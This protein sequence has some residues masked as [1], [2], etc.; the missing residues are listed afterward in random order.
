MDS[1]TVLLTH[2]ARVCGL[3]VLLSCSAADAAQAQDRIEIFGALTGILSAPSGTVV[4]D[5]APPLV[6]G[7]LVRSSAGQTLPVIG[8]DGIGVQAGI[9]LFASS[10]FG[11][12]VI[13]DRAN[14]DLSARNGPYSVSL[15][16]VSI[17]PPATVPAVFT[18]NVAKPWPDTIGSLTQWTACF[19]AIARTPVRRVSAS[20]SG[21]L[22]WTRLSGDAQALAYTEFRL[23]GHS[24]LFSDEAHLAFALE[25]V[26]TVGFN[27]GADVDLALSPHAAIV[28]GY[29]YLGGKT[30]DMPVSL[31]AITTE[32]E[33]IVRTPLADIAERLQ[34][35]PARV[36]TTGSRLAI[37]VK[38]RF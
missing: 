4:T 33:L 22:A 28:A 27:A 16:Y 18:M 29:R 24:V 23:G 3:M 32:E 12:Q 25:P 36:R 2:A 31:T 11:F 20:M 17:Q 6:N 1:V 38:F 19:N 10:R 37:G 5:Y 8:N 34:V 9:N 35:K 30:V 14:V 7:T 21:G 26:N 15:E 13:V